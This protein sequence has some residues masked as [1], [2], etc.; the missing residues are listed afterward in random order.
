MARQGQTD[1][2]QPKRPFVPDP[3]HFL[4]WLFRR[5]CVHSPDPPHSLH[6]LFCRPCVHSPDRPHSLHRLLC[7]SC[8][9]SP[10]RPHSLRNWPF[11]DPCGQKF[12]IVSSSSATPRSTDSPTSYPFE[13]SS[14]QVRREAT[15]KMSSS[16]CP[17][18]QIIAAGD[19]WSCYTT[20]S[21]E[22]PRLLYVLVG[23]PLQEAAHQA[24]PLL[25]RGALAGKQQEKTYPGKSNIRILTG[26]G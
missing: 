1:T 18:T 20:S 13:A 21:C 10:D 6:W 14:S 8:V 7:R 19:R 9:H 24:L 22:S 25:A 26:N 12:E 15:M 17:P 3:P 4:Y 5:P 23:L 2:A 11:I 16:V